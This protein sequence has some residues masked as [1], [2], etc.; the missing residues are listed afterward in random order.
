M[1]RQGFDLEVKRRHVGDQSRMHEVGWVGARLGAVL[2]GA[3]K[4][5]R[6]GPNGLQEGWHAE[7]VE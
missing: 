5:A 6:D 1:M 3:L 7:V 4:E 2:R